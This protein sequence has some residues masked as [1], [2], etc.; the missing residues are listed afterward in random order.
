ML[1]PNPENARRLCRERF[2]ELAVIAAGLLEHPLP[3][4]VKSGCKHLRE[5]A[6]SFSEKVGL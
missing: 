1:P 4:P 6:E 5:I 2:K 3:D